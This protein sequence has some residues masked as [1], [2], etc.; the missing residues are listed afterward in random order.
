MYFLINKFV[1]LGKY[2]FEKVVLLLNDGPWDVMWWVCWRR[3][4]S[5]AC[6]DVLC[7]PSCP[8][9]HQLANKDALLLRILSRI[10]CCQTISFGKNIYWQKC[11]PR[12]SRECWYRHTQR[13][14]L[15]TT[16]P[17][18]PTP[19]YSACIRWTLI[20]QDLFSKSLCH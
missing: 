16:I 17:L 1:C 7:V 18:M 8:E 6:I 14:E 2:D 19:P 12:S 4:L 5:G 3:E 20:R 11:L 10:H 9:Q 15:V 13:N